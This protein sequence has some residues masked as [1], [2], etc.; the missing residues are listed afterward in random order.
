MLLHE[1][2]QDH[3]NFD[4]LILTRWVTRGSTGDLEG[5]SLCCY[6]N[7]REEGKLDRECVCV[8]MCMCAYGREVIY[9]HVRYSSLRPYKFDYLMYG[10]TDPLR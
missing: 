5:L 9:I 10:P 2:I 8:Y 4:Y 3:Y 1:A 6:G 7:L